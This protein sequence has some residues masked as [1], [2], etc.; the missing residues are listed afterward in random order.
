LRAI[1]FELG[2]QGLE[3]GDSKP[4]AY[5][6]RPE[7]VADTFVVL[8]QQNQV[9]NLFRN[10]D[11]T[12]VPNALALRWATTCG[13]P[14]N[15]DQASIQ[16]WNKATKPMESVLSKWAEAAIALDPTTSTSFEKFNAAT[17]KLLNFIPTQHSMLLDAK[18][19]TIQK[20]PEY[21]KNNARDGLEVLN[22]EIVK[23]LEVMIAS[24]AFDLEATRTLEVQVSRYQKFR[25]TTTTEKAAQA[26]KDG[27]S[28]FWSESKAQIL[29][30]IA[31]QADDG[32]A[33]SDQLDRAFNENLSELLDNWTTE[34]KKIPK[35][36]PVALHDAAWKLRFTIRRYRRS[37]S[38]ILKVQAGFRQR[39]LTALDGLQ[40]A[41]AGQIQHYRQQKY[42]LF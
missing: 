29:K 7:V 13:Q 11:I 31:A 30:D 1:T 35:H 18:N 39:L 22:D 16:A 34:C 17:T 36:D 26:A 6:S 28:D 41:L 4:L 37:V 27:F 20:V 9:A 19:P 24:G 42:R 14:K 23:R 12:T 15:V 2:R 33:L 40:F 38:G 32:K 3:L 8:T 10:A 25:Q 5:G 21:L